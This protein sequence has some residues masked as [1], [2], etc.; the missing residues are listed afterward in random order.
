MKIEESL[1]L[2]LN[3]SK[4]QTVLSRRFEGQ[5]GGLGSSEFVILFHLSLAPDENM[6]RIDLAEKIGLTA[7]GI[8]RLLLP[9]EKV[10]YV[11]KVANENDARSSLVSLAPGG[12][13]KLTDA[14]ERANLFCDGIFGNLKGKD[15]KT[16]A[17][18]MLDLG[19]SVK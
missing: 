7:S 16:V 11:K 12:K 19:G 1:K 17:K 3:M 6:R 18:L 10:G 8:T 2:F 13:R 5:L 4:V 9:M 14:L 15:F